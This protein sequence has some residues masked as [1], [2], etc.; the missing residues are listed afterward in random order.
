MSCWLR[1]VCGHPCDGCIR[2]K[3]L[4]HYPRL[5]H[6]HVIAAIHGQPSALNGQA[7]FHST[8]MYHGRG[9]ERHAVNMA[10]VVGVESEYSASAGSQGVQQMSG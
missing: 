10:S 9:Q 4:P 8:G 6:R 2:G 5:C 7:E 1:L 3:R